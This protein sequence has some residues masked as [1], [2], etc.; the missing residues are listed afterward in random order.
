[1]AAFPLDRLVDFLAMDWD[2]LGSLDSQ[3]NLVAPNV[4]DRHHDVIANHDAFITLS[5]KDK[6]RWLLPKLSLPLSY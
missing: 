5:G 6:H 3:A 1:V 4:D 2:F